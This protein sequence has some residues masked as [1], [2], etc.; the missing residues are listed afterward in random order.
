M[1]DCLRSVQFGLRQHES[2][3]DFTLPPE[4]IVHFPTAHQSFLE[5]GEVG[6]LLHNVD[7]FTH[8]RQEFSGEAAAT[9]HDES[10][11]FAIGG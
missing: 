4:E 6:F 11:D 1:K 2:L 5:Q 3:P 7:L 9:S 8:L 10:C